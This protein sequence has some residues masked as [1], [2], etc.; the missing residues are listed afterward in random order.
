M[1]TGHLWG[2][3]SVKGEYLTVFEPRQQM[4]GDDFEIFHHLDAQSCNVRP[5]MHDFYELYCPLSEGM[6]YIVEGKIYALEPGQLL[7]IGPGET[8]RPDIEDG[9]EPFE[10]IVLWMNAEFVGSLTGTLPLLKRTLLSGLKGRNLIS[11]DVETYE[12]L[13][14]LMLSL[15]REKRLDAPDSP[16][17]CRLVATQLLIHLS[18]Y[19]ARTPGP[20]SLRTGHR[21]AEVMRVYDY[22][23]AHLSDDLSVAGLAELFFMD[24]NTLTRQFKRLVGMTP[25]ECIRKL[26]LQA[27]HAMISGGVSM[28]VACT[29]CGFSDYSAFYRAFRQVYGLSPSAYAAK[30][31]GKS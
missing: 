8:H 22:I 20:A 1:I 11:P 10:R 14:G 2:G 29:E 9:A 30:A 25:G 18:R 21:D 7:L 6:R 12:I 23:R 27:A 31:R 16:V 26:R 28:Q 3:G 13:R 17:L 15:L 19:L 4:R 5:H 24:K